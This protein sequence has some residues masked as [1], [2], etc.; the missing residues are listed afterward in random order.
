MNNLLYMLCKCIMMTTLWLSPYILIIIGLFVCHTSLC[1][2]ACIIF[3]II[4]ALLT[5]PITSMI[6][7]YKS[8]T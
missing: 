5:R 8:L 7:A 1:M 3:G 4:L 6:K 2:W